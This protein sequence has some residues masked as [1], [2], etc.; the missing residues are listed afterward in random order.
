MLLL[1]SSRYLGLAGVWTV[2]NDEHLAACAERRAGVV[3]IASCSVA[4]A[5]AVFA[6]AAGSVI[7]G[8]CGRKR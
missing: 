4:S 5:A 8:V 6:V 3:R 7:L 1:L 2:G